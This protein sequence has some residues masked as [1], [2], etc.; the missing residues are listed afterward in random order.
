MVKIPPIKMVGGMVYGIVLTTLKEC[1]HPG[2]GL[3]TIYTTY[4][5]DWGMVN[6]A[7]VYP[8]ESVCCRDVCTAV[9]MSEDDV[10][11]NI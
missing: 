4:G 7:L 3:V 9:E 8:H 6:I 10:R 11:C 1:H 2:L 5:D